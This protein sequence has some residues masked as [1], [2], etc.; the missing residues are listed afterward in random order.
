MECENCGQTGDWVGEDSEWSDAG[1]GLA[2]VGLKECEV[3]GHKQRA[4]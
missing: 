3:C 2:V 4:R 1:S